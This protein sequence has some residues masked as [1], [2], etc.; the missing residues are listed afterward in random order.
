MALPVDGKEETQD[1]LLFFFLIFASFF[2]LG[3]CPPS[4]LLTRPPQTLSIS[5]CTVISQ[6][7]D[8]ELKEETHTFVEGVLAKRK[9]T[10]HTLGSDGPD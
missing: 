10:D 9:G 1:S 5:K 8:P 6:Y 4:F 7:H 2:L 3:H